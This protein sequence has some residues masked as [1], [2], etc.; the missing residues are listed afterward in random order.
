MRLYRSIAKERRKRNDV[1]LAE[2]F[3][4]LLGWIDHQNNL[5]G[6]KALAEALPG[7]FRGVRTEI[8]KVEQLHGWLIESYAL[9]G[10]AD[11]HHR[12]DLVSLDTTTIETLAFRAEAMDSDLV[13]LRDCEAALH[14]ILGYCPS[15]FSAARRSGWQDVIAFLE[16]VRETLTL[17]VRLLGRRG[18]DEL[19]ALRIIQLMQAKYEIESHQ[20]E[21][22]ALARGVD[23]LRAAG[24]RAY[25][26][27]FSNEP[28]HW[29]QT[30]G[31]V[32][33]LSTDCEALVRIVGR[34]CTE[35]HYGFSSYRVHRRKTC[36]G[37]FF[38]TVDYGASFDPLGRLYRAV[39]RGS[40]PLACPARTTGTQC[41]S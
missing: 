24:G 11:L 36:D 41:S 5:E 20:T 10:S 17:T 29:S 38:R 9:L 16:R 23:E 15:G 39:A 3:S 32:S 19:P 34:F 6:D 40:S 12:V 37:S 7:L 28:A 26:R 1:E 35:Y 4:L 21:I 14:D 18:L 33:D 2:A 31:E 27:S 22:A 13:V 25:E 30:I 8:A